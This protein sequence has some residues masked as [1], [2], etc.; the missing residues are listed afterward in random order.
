[1]CQMRADGYSLRE[2]GEAFGVTRERARQIIREADGPD[3]AE[4][5]SAR[6]ERLGRE[7]E[8]LR[9]RALALASAEPG[10]TVEETAEL[11]GVTQRALRAAL[12][13]D[14]RRYFLNRQRGTRV[15]SDA[16]ILAHLREAARL[17]G[18]P[19][20]VRAYEQVR[21]T[22]GGASAPLV[23]QRFGTWHKACVGAGVQHG[24]AVR[25]HYQR[26]WSLDEMLQAVAAYLTRDGARGSFADYERWAR[27]NDAAPSG[28]TIRTQFGTWSRAK[29]EAL[30]L[31]VHRRGA[32]PGDSRS[33]DAEG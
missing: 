29:A 16:V 21:S 23:L 11:L 25:R 14:A 9:S 22:F 26:R 27:A 12:G 4:A 1:M 8:E 17:V 33:G 3:S 20:T 31:V 28:Q 15:F 13:D 5:A 6:R 10:R 24:Q 19:L 32:G 2:I 30:A 7:R 18:E